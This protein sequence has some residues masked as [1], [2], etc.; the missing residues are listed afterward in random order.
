MRSG[1]YEL[2]EV[3]PASG[4]L[5]LSQ[6]AL[7]FNIASVYHLNNDAQNPAATVE[8]LSTLDDGTLVGSGI[9]DGVIDG[10]EINIVN[11]Q[12]SIFPVTGKGGLLILLLI[13]G[14]IMVATLVHRGKKAKVRA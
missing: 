12:Q 9:T 6:P 14:L 2:Q 13:G 5:A 11:Y 8:D 3:K 10:N 1:Q 4:Y 7:R